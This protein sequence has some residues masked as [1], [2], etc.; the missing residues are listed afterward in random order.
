MQQAAAECPNGCSGHG[1][2]KD[3]DQCKCDPG[4]QGADC[5]ERTCPSDFAWVDAPRGDLNHNGKLDTGVDG[6]ANVAWSNVKEYEMFPTGHPDIFAAANDEA[7]FYAECSNKGAC[8]RTTGMCKCFAGYTG[9]ACQRTTCPKDCSGRGVCRTLREIA[10]NA[11]NKRESKSV[12]GHKQF[13][14]VRNPFDY[15]RWDADKHQSCV[16]DPGFTGVDCSQRQCPRG[17]DPLTPA[18]ARWC[19]GQA[20]S[21]EIQS[22]CIPSAGTVTYRLGFTDSLNMTHHAYATLDTSGTM[23]YVSD[24]D[25]SSKLPGP[26]TVAGQ[27]MNSLRAIPGG[28]LQRVEVYPAGDSSNVDANVPRT[29]RVTFVGV[30]G[31]QAPLSVEVY[32]GSVTGALCSNPDHPIYG[33]TPASAKKVVEVTHGNYEG[34]E[35][36]GRGVCDYGG[37]ACKCFAGFFGAACEFQNALT[38]GSS[39]SGG[40]AAAAAAAAAPAA[41]A[42]G[43]G[44]ATA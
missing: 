18:L 33:S 26:T 27:L 20:C 36:S 4:F 24:A 35:C 25:K 12:A 37:G 16:C 7:H 17:D 44:S 19:G 29:F 32:G 28:L 31:D 38:A 21:W 15:N 30:S 41:A 14:G 3:R 34:L 6:Y 39:S 11:L 23:G 13:T 9:S 10:A 43:A 1:V 40:A 8:D 2:C 22:F 42:A 5:S